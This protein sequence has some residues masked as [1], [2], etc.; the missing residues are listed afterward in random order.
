MQNRIRQ[1]LIIGGIFQPFL[2]F[3]E[4]FKYSGSSWAVYILYLLFLFIS[5]VLFI[6]PMTETNADFVKNNPKTYTFLSWIGWVPYVS[7]PLNFKIATFTHGIPENWYNF[8]VTY[9]EI[10]EFSIPASFVLAIIM[11]I[12]KAHDERGIKKAKKRYKNIY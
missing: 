5:C 6:F 7:I 3:F 4:Y 8:V 10:Y 2:L 1:C 11:V 12:R 9:I